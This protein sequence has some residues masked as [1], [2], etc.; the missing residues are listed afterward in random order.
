MNV[1][2]G[3]VGILAEFEGFDISGQR[4]TAV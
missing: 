2:F 1:V 3:G 4:L